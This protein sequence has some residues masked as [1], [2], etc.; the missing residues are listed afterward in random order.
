METQY[1]QHSYYI[2][3]QGLVLANVGPIFFYS[4][5]QLNSN[6]DLNLFTVSKG[7]EN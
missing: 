5:L 2:L 6:I 3:C 7:N 4:S 1:G